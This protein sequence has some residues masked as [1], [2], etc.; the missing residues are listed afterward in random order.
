MGT[1]FRLRYVRSAL[2]TAIIDIAVGAPGRRRMTED[3][4]ESRANEAKHGERKKILARYSI[5]RHCS[6]MN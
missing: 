5:V 6:V 2:P 4:F 1:N 3:C